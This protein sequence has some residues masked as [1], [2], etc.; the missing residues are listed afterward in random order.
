VINYQELAT[1]VR[2]GHDANTALGA[3]WVKCRWCGMWL[4]EVKAIE[5]RE[6]TPPREEQDLLSRLKDEGNKP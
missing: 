3:G 6:D 4:R 1:C 2:R 5:E